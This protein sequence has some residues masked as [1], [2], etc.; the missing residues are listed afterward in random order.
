LDVDNLTHVI[1]YNL[2][3]ELESYVHRSGRT[4][5]AGK[6]GISVSLVSTRDKS[7]ISI[8]EKNIKKKFEARSIPDGRECCEKQLFHMVETMEQVAVND[9][10]ID[11]F[12][13]VIYKKLEGMTREEL[14]KRFV[15]TEFNRFL[16]YYKDAPDLNVRESEFRSERGE[17]GERGDRGPRSSAPG[18]RKRFDDEGLVP[19]RINLGFRDGLSPTDLLRLIK[20]YTPKTKVKVGKVTIMKNDT[21]FEADGAYS[22]M[23]M[24]AFRDA[25]IADRKISLRKTSGRP[26]KTFET[27]RRFR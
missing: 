5:R 23:L 11:D 19:F 3:D 21:I 4:G 13:P 25:Y 9:E 6:S 10:E 14:I 17:R 15:S 16:D 20:D 12:L 26:E 24:D 7:K 18:E 8:L 1:N 2:P 27:K 22:D